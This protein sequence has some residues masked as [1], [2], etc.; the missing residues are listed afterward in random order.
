MRQSLVVEH[1]TQATREPMAVYRHQAVGET[2]ARECMHEGRPVARELAHA[3]A[4]IWRHM[5][6][7]RGR[8]AYLIFAQHFRRK[9]LPLQLSL[10]TA[11]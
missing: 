8:G 10:E 7:E 5:R 3:M 1:P 4:N 11:P 2:Q 6:W 9:A